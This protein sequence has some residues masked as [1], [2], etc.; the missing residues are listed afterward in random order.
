MKVLL[1]GCSGFV[2]AQVARRLLDE[3]H[4]VRA[5]YLPGDNLSRIADILDRMERREGDL[6]HATDD[7]LARLCEGVDAC[8]HLAW[9]VIPGKYL[10]APENLDCVK[11]SVR[12][13]AA[14]GQAGC[15]RIA[16]VG[17]CFEYDFS[18]G[19]LSESTPTSADSLYA[20]AKTATLLMGEQ[21]ARLHDIGFA[22]PR[23]F[24]LYGPGEDPRRL[25]PH[26]INSLLRG[27]PAA[28]TSGR[29][30]RDFMHV[31]DV[32]GGLVAAL[33]SDLTGPVNVGSGE[34]VTVRQIV[35][36]IAGILGRPDLV[37]FG[38]RP[39]NPTDPPFIVANNQKLLST[40]WRPRYDLE[41]GLGHAIGWWR[42][43][44]G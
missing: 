31:E 24:Y 41:S 14:L 34:P 12:L 36:T 17:T 22:W 42:A 4:Q 28:V 18:Y 32:A 33:L 19:Y 35:A 26:V 27:E 16:S 38:A 44:A 15:R 21:V 20:A 10:P 25:V 29:Q 23:L 2:G 39:D 8:L 7:D 30:V 13:F 5:S 37:Q 6:F 3:G 9:F 40:G 1:T 11:G 43:Q